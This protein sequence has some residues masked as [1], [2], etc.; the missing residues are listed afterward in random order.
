M[1]TAIIQVL[2]NIKHNGEV[3]KAGDFIEREV[4]E[5]A[6]AIETGVMRV[7]NVKTID[8]AEAIVSKEVERAEKIVAP[9]PPENTFEAKPDSS[10]DKVQADPNIAKFTVLKDFTIN[11]KD[12]KNFGEH[13]V[14]EVIE[15]DPTA[16]QSMIDDGTLEL[17]VEPAPEKKEDAP[18]PPAGDNL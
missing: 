18:L 12:S 5:F 4:A 15:A 11:N 13:K 8:E 1:K 14:G 9:E 16:A 2:S 17:F 7:F 10:K 3:L 6:Q